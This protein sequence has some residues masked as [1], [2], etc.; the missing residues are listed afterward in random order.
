VKDAA[1]P[2]STR[3]GTRLV[4]LVRGKGEEAATDESVDGVPRGSF[5]EHRRARAQL[6]VV[7]PHARAP[8]PRVRFVQ[9]E[10]RDLSCS[11]RHQ[12][13]SSGHALAVTGGGWISTSEISRPSKRVAR[14]ACPGSESDGGAAAGS[15]ALHCAKPGASAAQLENSLMGRYDAAKDGR[16]HADPAV[17][18]GRQR[19]RGVGGRG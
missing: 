3:G 15:E 18:P 11:A 2:I 19:S 1:C 10:I 17:S 9:L 16:Q 12:G 14:N 13:V 8:Q 5:A 4:R 6:A 7:E